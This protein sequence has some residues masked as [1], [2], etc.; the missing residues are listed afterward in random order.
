MEIVLLVLVIHDLLCWLLGHQ[1]IGDIL[2]S[3][4]TQKYF[5][6][7]TSRL[8]IV[9]IGFKKLLMNRAVQTGVAAFNT[10][11]AKN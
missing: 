1:V 8:E 6:F 11:R 5:S 7:L 9:T 2:N 10:R 3:S 4:C